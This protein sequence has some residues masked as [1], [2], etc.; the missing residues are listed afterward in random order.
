MSN[1]LVGIGVWLLSDA[2]YSITLYLNAPS[3]DG[4]PKQTFRQDHWV[5]VLR[6]ILA[7]TIIW[8]GVNG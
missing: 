6:A 7:I 2:V 8:T 4:K 5:R 1:L 3:Y